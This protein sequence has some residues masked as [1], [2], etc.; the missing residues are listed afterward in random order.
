MQPECIILLVLS[1][2]NLN[3]KCYYNGNTYVYYN[4]NISGF[5]IRV[6]YIIKTFSNKLKQ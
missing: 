2:I 5:S 3:D 1:L 4:N 6:Y